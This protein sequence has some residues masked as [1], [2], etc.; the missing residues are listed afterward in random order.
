[1]ISLRYTR[2]SF[3]KARNVESSSLN[4]SSVFGYSSKNES[5]FYG[6]LIFVK[7]E[8]IGFASDVLPSFCKYC[9][10]RSY[11]KSMESLLTSSNDDRFLIKPSKDS[12]SLK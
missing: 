8:K 12:L 11:Q 4:S 7:R 1:M 2:P 5:L 3:V 9:R 10:K 6:H